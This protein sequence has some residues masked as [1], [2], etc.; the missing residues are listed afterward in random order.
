MVCATTLGVESQDIAMLMI[1]GMGG[2]VL[3]VW[4]IA[5]HVADVLK[6][7]QVQQTKR[8][9][10]A[11]VAE[12]SITPEDAVRLLSSESSDLEKQIGTAVAWGTI[13]PAKAAELL[14]SVREG[15]STS[16]E[17]AAKI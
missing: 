2:L 7:R 3:L 14:K 13:S 5:K 11:Y 8:E 16:R 17:A 4:I 1:F 12:G 10:A 6:T 15:R 9:V